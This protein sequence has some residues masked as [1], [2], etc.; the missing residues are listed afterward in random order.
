MESSPTYSVENGVRFAWS[1]LTGNLNPERV[2]LLEK[3]ICGQEVLDAGC[4]GGAFTEYLGAKGLHVIGLDYHA[5]FLEVARARPGATGTY[6]EGDIT[7]LPFP[8]QRFDCTYCFDVLEHVDD[9]KALAELIRVTQKRVIIAVPAADADLIGGGLTFHHYR[10]LTHL[11]TY[12]EESLQTLFESLGQRNFRIMPELPVDFPLIASQ[13]LQSAQTSNPLKATARN[14][15]HAL[16]R[17]LLNHA[18]YTAIYSGWT[19][20]IDLTSGALP[21]PQP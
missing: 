2:G 1:S 20:V 7:A 16:L 10:D 6:V 15:Y 13:H 12:T 14:V 17:R 5:M 3:N 8:D 21:L 11:R 9:A 19:A 18:R 4:G